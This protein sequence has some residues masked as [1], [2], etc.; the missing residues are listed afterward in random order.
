VQLFYYRDK[1]GNFGDDLNPWIWPQILGK[2]VEAVLDSSYVLIGIGTILSDGHIAKLK[3]PPEK[4]VVMGSGV[5]YGDIV[6]SRTALRRCPRIFVRGPHTAAVL[7]LPAEKVIVDPGVL[8]SRLTPLPVLRGSRHKV[9]VL[10]HH[11]HHNLC[12]AA[13]AHICSELG[14]NYVNVTRKPE[15]VLPQLLHSDL[16]ISESMHGAICAD[17]L[18]VPWIPFGTSPVINVFKWM[19]WSASVSLSMEMNWV[20]ALTVQRVGKQVR[21]ERAEAV[22][23][24][25]RRLIEHAPRYLCPRP[26]LGSLAE[27][28]LEF[29]GRLLK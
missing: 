8:I 16:V 17:A 2:P 12:G 28:I 22:T 18:G 9:S 4:L 15:E 14:W 10:L 26:L 19:D 7:G 13:W 11:S 23:R 1:I 6:R 25:L 24:Q 21:V 20:S 3:A 27:R 29:T 5:G